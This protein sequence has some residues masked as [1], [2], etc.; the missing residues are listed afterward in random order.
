ML[1]DDILVRRFHL[2]G[3]RDNIRCSSLVATRPIQ[4]VS[5]ADGQ[6][7]GS[8]IFTDP[9]YGINHA[10]FAPATSCAARSGSGTATQPF[11]MSF[12]LSDKISSAAGCASFTFTEMV[13]SR[14]KVHF[15]PI[16]S[17]KESR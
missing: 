5:P 2:G 7:E 9:P 13:I 16:G 10:N 6:C 3:G 15:H 17:I 1:V 4:R 14:S 12:T 11:A 8:A